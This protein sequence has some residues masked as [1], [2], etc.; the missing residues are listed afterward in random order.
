MKDKFTK[1]Q[2]LLFTLTIFTSL[3][4]FSLSIVPSAEA[5]IVVIG[6][7]SPDL[8]D[9]YYQ[10]AKDIANKL[11]A[12]GYNSS[13][14]LELYKENA[15]AKNILKGM[16]NADL[17][18]Y[19]GHGGYQYGHYDGNGGTATPPFSIVGYA[20]EN[21]YSGKEF[22]WGIGEQMREGWS[23][24][25]FSAPFKQDIPVM[26]FHA[27]FSTGDVE[28]KQVANPVE[29]I[30]NF[31]QMFTG[32]GANYYASA[33]FD[34]GIIDTFLNGASDFADANNK[35]SY[36]PEKFTKNYTYNG[37]TIWRSLGGDVAFIGDLG[38]KF[39]SKTD[40]TPYDDI[41]AEAWYNSDRVK[42]ELI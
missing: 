36:S 2:S 21:D 4:L 19:I 1:F 16:Y 20:P 40:I 32:A 38:G 18:I 11:K 42:R 37:T 27:C 12:K 17:V 10:D 15:S 34:S 3:F 5:H 8:P 29:T 31:A 35:I 7:P 14:I 24:N 30:Y 13:D 28:D 26:L 6:A 33:W 25:L 23:G 41:A 22:I 9:S 39:P